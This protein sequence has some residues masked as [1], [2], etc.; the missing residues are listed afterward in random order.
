MCQWPWVIPIVGFSITLLFTGRCLKQYI[1]YCHLIY[2]QC[3]APLAGMWSLCNSWTSCYFLV[4][5]DSL[6]LT[7]RLS[8]LQCTLNSVL[9]LLWSLQPQYCLSCEWFRLCV[10]LCTHRLTS[11]P[12]TDIGPCSET[13]SA[14]IGSDCVSVCGLTGRPVVQGL[15]LVL[16]VKLS[17]LW[18]V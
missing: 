9:S 16:A 10:C 12:R 11:C 5:C 6:K 1:L 17:Q 8:D 3:S 14:V 18:V 2:I 15:T 13:V 7:D 4:M